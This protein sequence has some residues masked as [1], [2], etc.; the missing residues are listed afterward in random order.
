MSNL[1]HSLSSIAVAQTH[2]DAL[3]TMTENDT[4]EMVEWLEGS[5]SVGEWRMANSY[6]GFVILE[7]MALNPD[8]IP[9]GWRVSD[10]SGS[11]VSIRKE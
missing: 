8:K 9:D 1:L 10:I 6:Q 11:H 4:V 3:Q 7:P 5:C 2:C